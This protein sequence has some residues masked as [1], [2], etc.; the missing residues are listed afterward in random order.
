MEFQFS[1][2]TNTLTVSIALDLERLEPNFATQRASENQLG[3]VKVL[4]PSQA[5]NASLNGR[6]TR[7]SPNQPVLEAATVA[8]TTQRSHLQISF[9]ED[10]PFISGNMA[11]QAR[12]NRELRA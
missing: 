2:S 8:Q 11:R 6:S 3:T 10:V 7:A 9:H 5:P 12:P 4:G 1:P